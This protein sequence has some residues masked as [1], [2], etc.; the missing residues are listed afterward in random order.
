MG[1]CLTKSVV[2]DIETNARRSMKMDTAILWRRF[3]PIV[4]LII[5]ALLAHVLPSDAQ[6]Q[7]PCLCVLDMHSFI[8]GPDSKNYSY[9]SNI[10]KP[11]YTNAS[12][13]SCGMVNAR[14]DGGLLDSSAAKPD[15]SFWVPSSPGGPLMG[16][17]THT[18]SAYCQGCNTDSNGVCQPFYIDGDAVQFTANSTP[19]NVQITSAPP[20]GTVLGPGPVV[21]EGVISDLT[22]ATTVYFGGGS[23]QAVSGQWT[24]ILPGPQ[25]SIGFWARDV[26]GN[27][28]T[29][30]TAPGGQQLGFSTDKVDAHLQRQYVVDLTPPTVV[31]LTTG[32]LKSF[33]SIIGTAS[34]EH[35]VAEVDIAIS[36]GGLYWDGSAFTSVAQIFH[37]ASGAEAWS[38]GFSSDQLTAGSGINVYWTATDSVGNQTTVLGPQ[39]INLVPGLDIQPTPVA[40]SISFATDSLIIFDKATWYVQYGLHKDNSPNYSRPID[41]I[42]AHKN[43]S[44]SADINPDVTQLTLASTTGAIKRFSPTTS[45]GCQYAWTVESDPSK[46]LDTVDSIIATYN[47]NVVGHTEIDVVLPNRTTAVRD[48][49][50]DGVTQRVAGCRLDPNNS[51]SAITNCLQDLFGVTFLEPT[52]AGAPPMNLFDQ[53]FQEKVA[54]IQ[55]DCQ[56]TDSVQIIAGLIDRTDNTVGDYNGFQ[57]LQFMDGR[58]FI[59]KHFPDSVAA[60][61]SL[62][63]TPSATCSQVHTQYFKINRC[64]VPRSG[65][66]TLTQTLTYRSGTTLSYGFTTQRT[67]LGAP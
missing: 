22:L 7:A 27:L 64:R 11:L 19:P 39:A 8:V 47:G 49:S 18:V 44:A 5:V 4:G 29:F 45:A 2:L 40:L 65:A 41:V 3:A 26:I 51:Q 9:G 31:I 46:C 59:A 66:A 35:G 14:L 20:N 43:P 16:D 53:S 17:G 38:Y 15:G 52:V 54:P 24:V 62:G 28:V 10:F 6:S 61:I 25:Q 1:E 67:D 57:S 34:D 50:I 60:S 13:T 21:I 42:C 37:R 23:T 33:N 12:D 56:T 63:T 36:N 30:S 55:N 58:T 32:T 48:Q